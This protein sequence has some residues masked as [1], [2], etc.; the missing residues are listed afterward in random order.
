MRPVNI[1]S[2]EVK[3]LFDY[4]KE[5]ASIGIPIESLRHEVPVTKAISCANR[6][7]VHKLQT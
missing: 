5:M 6:Q 4:E 2:Q 7:Y 1:L 3:C